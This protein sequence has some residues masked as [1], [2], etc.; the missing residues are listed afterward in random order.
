M[1][2]GLVNGWNDCWVWVT[3]ICTTCPD[4]LSVYQYQ[5]YM[6]AIQF[7]VVK[8]DFWLCLVN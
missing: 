2:S 3:A 7:S 8:K 1:S 5:P 6:R 4:I